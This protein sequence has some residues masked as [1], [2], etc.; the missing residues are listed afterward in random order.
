MGNLLENNQNVQKSNL[1][2]VGLDNAGKTTIL[3]QLQRNKVE[4]LY[5]KIGFYLEKIQYKQF[6]I[7]SW[8]IGGSDPRMQIYNPNGFTYNGIIFVVDFNDKERIECSATEFH[9]LLSMENFKELP[10][11]ILAN[12][13]DLIKVNIQE[14]TRELM[15]EKL[16]NIFHIQPC[17]AVKGEGLEDGLKWM[18][19]QLK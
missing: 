10:I 17:C 16:S 5:P 7:F 2:M 12:K 1:M 18:Q 8:D 6:E 14:M 4:T 9:R 11:L 13:K 15:L 19:K 3:Y